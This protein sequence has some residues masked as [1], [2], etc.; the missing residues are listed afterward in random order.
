MTDVNKAFNNNK[1]YFIIINKLHLIAKQLI[2]N[3]A[4]TDR[5]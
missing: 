4:K 1:T 2:M 5:T 3:E